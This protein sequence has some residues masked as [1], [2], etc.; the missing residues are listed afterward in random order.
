MNFI[1]TTLWKSTLA[2]REDDPDEAPRSMLR[3][4]YF[5]MRDHVADLVSSIPDSCRGLTVHDISHLDALWDVASTIAGQDYQ[6]TPAEAFVFGGAVLLHDSGLSIMAYKGGLEDLKLTSEWRDASSSIVRQRFD[7]RATPEELAS[8]PP[9]VLEGVIFATLRALHARQ[10]E[11]LSTMSWP[12]PKRAGEEIRLLED[13]ALRG[14]YG[15]SIGRIAHSHHW[16]ATRLFV[17]LNQDVG[18]AAQLPASWT[19]N[20]VK[21]ACLLRCTDAAHIDHRRAPTM[22]FALTN[23]TGSSVNHWSFQNKIHQVLQ[24][25]D[26]LVYS[27]GNSFTT[28]EADAWWLCFDTITMIDRELTSCANLMQDANISTF[29]VRRVIGAESP[30]ILAKHI[31]TDGWRPVNAEVRV[32]DPIRLAQTLGGRNLYGRD[33]TASFRELLQ[34]STDA[35]RARRLYEPRPADFGKIRLSFEKASN[36]TYWVH[37]DDNGIGMSESVLTT[38][39]LDFGKSFWATTKAQEEFPG[40]Q[41]RG[42]EPIGRYG[43]G[44]FSVFLVGEKV[45]VTSRRF[46]AALADART[47]EFKTLASRPILRSAEAGELPI[48]FSTRISVLVTEK[49]ANQTRFGRLVRASMEYLSGNQAVAFVTATIRRLIAPLDVDVEIIDHLNNQTYRHSAHWLETESA[50][51]LDEL[52]SEAD[53][54]LRS[55]LIRAHKDSLAVIGDKSGQVYGR[56]AICFLGSRT[57]GSA[58]AF[59][60]VGGFAYP[61]FEP[62]LGSSAV[63][64]FLGESE[65]AAR[66]S[67]NLTIP[68]DILSTWAT[69][70]A[71]SCNPRQFSP[72]LLVQAAHAI[73]QI[74]GA[75]GPLPFCLCG[76]RLLSWHEFDRAVR[77]LP[78]V[79][80]GLR[81][82]YDKDNFRFEDGKAVGLLALSGMVRS[83]YIELVELEDSL[84]KIFTDENYIKRVV[85]EGRGKTKAED[86]RLSQAATGLFRT[87]E[88][89][90]GS[91]C[92]E[93]L[94]QQIKLPPTDMVRPHIQWVLSI[95]KMSCPRPM[96]DE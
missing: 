90:W 24:K 22:L 36:D 67:A 70:Q 54:S 61:T 2:K 44:F 95:G 13:S 86:I 49:I 81:V 1:Q 40:L 37:V 66:S 87:L 28:E 77:N 64:V 12:V 3:E 33:S 56:G 93:F 60:S 89:V 8:P 50:V 58:H 69:K 53:N 5:R 75:P 18:A 59:V 71:D 55:D 32:S 76:G 82:N 41:G 38:A 47:L 19:L 10:A 52:Y 85:E 6:L 43:I 96:Q 62:R 26:A 27:A 9:E 65:T 92:P 17:E 11:Q 73:L 63:G 23:P 30:S 21:V 48:D 83:D 16:N 14:A 39:L 31:K 80:I 88:L 46:D 45:R 15:K 78:E 7:R 29:A 57:T 91:V 74:G 20:E 51:F 84:S 72:T 34:N 35:I 94:L 4:A 25:E 42:L 68:D 79:H